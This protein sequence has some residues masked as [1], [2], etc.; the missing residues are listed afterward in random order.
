MRV[1]PVL[2]AFAAGLVTPRSETVQSGTR[3]LG[4]LSMK[5]LPLFFC[6]SGMTAGVSVSV[7]MI[8]PVII[9]TMFAT[10]TKAGG[11]FFAAF[12][13]MNR[14]DAGAITILINCRGLVGII[15]R[16]LAQ[17][18]GLIQSWPYSVLI[19]VSLLTTIIC[20]PALTWFRSSDSFEERSE[21]QVPQGALP[22]A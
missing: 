12:T 9:W 7:G 17:Q 2:A 4:N 14:L 13:T 8:L 6:Y 15:F 11:A 3:A 18:N 20:V 19:I 1:D 10:V 5:I 16:S 22:D 21:G